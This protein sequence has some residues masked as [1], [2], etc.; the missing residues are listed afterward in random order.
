MIG[1]FKGDYFISYG[2]IIELA[3]LA[4]IWDMENAPTLQYGIFK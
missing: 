3:P 4:N 1:L 2:L